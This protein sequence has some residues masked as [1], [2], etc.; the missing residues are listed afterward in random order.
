MNVILDYLKQH[1]EKLDTDIAAATGLAVEN[2]RA[3]LAELAA[4]NEVMI[5]Q[6]TRFVKGNKIESMSCRISGFIP[7]ASPG[8]KSKKVNLSL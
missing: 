5:C 1:G 3:Q 8:V 4:R 7:K 6:T 2:I